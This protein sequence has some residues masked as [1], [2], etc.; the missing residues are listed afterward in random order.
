MY[1]NHM[2][3]SWM[4]PKTTHLWHPGA[5]PNVDPM[6]GLRLGEPD[7]PATC[8]WFHGCPGWDYCSASSNP[9]PSHPQPGDVF[10]LVVWNMQRKR[11]RTT[12]RWASRRLQESPPWPSTHQRR[13]NRNQAESVILAEPFH[14]KKAPSSPWHH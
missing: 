9:K 12:A 7:S 5:D 13:R 14:V 3:Q 8:P 4:Y 1:W 11:S 2:F 10:P 6:Q